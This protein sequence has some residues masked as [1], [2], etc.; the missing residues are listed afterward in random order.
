MWSLRILFIVL[1]PVTRTLSFPVTPIPSSF[2]SDQ[3]VLLLDG[4]GVQDG[5]GTVKITVDAFVHRKQPD[6]SLFSDI[7]SSYFPVFRVLSEAQR[8]LRL[9]GASPMAAEVAI[10]FCDKTVKLSAGDDGKGLMEAVTVGN[11]PSGIRFISSQVQGE[12]DT[13]VATGKIFVSPPTGFGVISDI[14]DT[15]KLSYVRNKMKFVSTTSFGQARPVPGMPELYASL[16][17]SLQPAFIY[18]SASPFQLYP[19]L[20]QFIENDFSFSKG[21]IILRDFGWSFKKLRAFFERGGTLGYKSAMIARI[22]KLYPEKRFLMVGDSGEIDAA[23]QNMEFV[24]CI[25]IRKVPGAE[26]S[27]SRFARAFQGVPTN[28]WRV[29]DD[30]EIAELQDIDVGQEC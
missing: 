3:T 21:P 16:A 17:E 10:K 28:K 26:N 20:H 18:L 22:H 27:M 15:I 4:L 12:S 19:F 13:Q 24:S 25:W 11:C 2:S 14:D 29:F 23:T 9:L 5:Q 7:I 30:A 1:V 6:T 8:R